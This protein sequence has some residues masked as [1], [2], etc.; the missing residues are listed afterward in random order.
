M[1]DIFRLSSKNVHVVV[2][3]SNVRLLVGCTTASETN[4]V[5]FMAVNQ[6]SVGQ[7]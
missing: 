6:R 5:D 2:V 4:I 3:I 1:N 7:N